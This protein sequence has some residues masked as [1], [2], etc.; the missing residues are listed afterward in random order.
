MSA[1]VRGCLS[2]QSFDLE[3]GNLSPLF[4]NPLFDTGLSLNFRPDSLRSSESADKSAH[5]KLE[6]YRPSID[7]DRLTINASAI[8]GSQQQSQRRD[9]FRGHQTIL[10]AR[11]LEHRQC[12]VGRLAGLS[13][14]VFDA[15]RSHFSVDIARTN[16][17]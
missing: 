1:C 13:H 12:I 14:N 10:R 17:N 11:P 16:R 15:A 6:Q 2:F 7:I 5:S 3:W 9:F 8:L 4:I